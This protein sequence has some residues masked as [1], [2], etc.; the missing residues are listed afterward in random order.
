MDFPSGVMVTLRSTVTTTD[1]HGDSTSVV[2]EVP[3]GPCAVA[4]RSS[5]ERNDPH[6]P[7]VITGLTIYGPAADINAD[8]TLVLNGITYQIE[9]NPGVWASPFTGWAPGIEVAVRRAG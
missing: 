6:Q 7:A 3:W 5:E 2:T 8:D 9:G 4:P 1:D